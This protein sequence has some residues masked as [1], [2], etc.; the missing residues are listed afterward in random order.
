LNTRCSSLTGSHFPWIHGKP[1]LMN[2]DS[3]ELEI[4]S[5]FWTFVVHS[6]WWIRERWSCL[7][8]RSQLVFSS[9]QGQEEYSW[10]NAGGFKCRTNVQNYA[11]CFL[12]FF[13]VA[14][15]WTATTRI[16]PFAMVDECITKYLSVGS[17]IWGTVGN[18]GVWVFRRHFGHWCF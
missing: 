1:M 7:V 10:H 4:L 5:S 6:C 8:F 14:H 15:W 13:E 2:P 9:K 3:L 18:F 11:Y 17:I 16:I 12:E